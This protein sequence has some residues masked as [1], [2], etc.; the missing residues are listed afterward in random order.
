MVKYTDTASKWL[1]TSLLDGKLWIWAWPDHDQARKTTF[2]PAYHY[3]IKSLFAITLTSCTARIAVF[4]LRD[5]SYSP[6]HTVGRITNIIYTSCCYSSYS[7]PAAAVTPMD[8]SLSSYYSFLWILLL[9]KL[10]CLHSFYSAADY[11]LLLPL[12]LAPVPFLPLLS[13]LPL[14]LPP[15]Q[16]VLQSISTVLPTSSAPTPAPTTM[17]TIAPTVFRFLIIVTNFYYFPSLLL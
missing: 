15:P 6:T 16:Q 12:P 10:L 14:S 4:L 9:L 17:P 1:Q 7:S 2:K 5:C 11:R 3:H 13:P 8:P